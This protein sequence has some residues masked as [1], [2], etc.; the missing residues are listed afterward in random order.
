M[1]EILLI[2]DNP[3]DILLTREA[4]KEC[5]YKHNITAFKDGTEA[6][7]YLRRIGEYSNS[8]IPDLV[9]LDLNLPKKDGRELLAEIKSD[10]SM[11]CIP[12]IIMSTSRNEKDIKTS[13]ELKA[14][15]YICKPVELDSFINIIQSIE[16]FWLKTVSLPVYEKFI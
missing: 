4:F 9:L 1:S 3:A 5:L 11:S 2:E 10:N 16:K 15:C 12:V 6:L 13:Y 7:K 8:K 14:N